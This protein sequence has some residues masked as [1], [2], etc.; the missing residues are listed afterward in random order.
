MEIPGWF[1]S[2]LLILIIGLLSRLVLQFDSLVREFR[3]LK[4]QFIRAEVKRAT[5]EKR[6]DALEVE[7][8]D[9]RSE[10]SRHLYKR[11]DDPAN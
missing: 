3:D 8:Q 7:V 9:I 2:I 6:L 4:E 10:L 11:A 5:H 1:A